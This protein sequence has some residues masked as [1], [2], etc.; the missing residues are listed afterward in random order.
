MR[1]LHV[2]VVLALGLDVRMPRDENGGAWFL[3]FNGPALAVALY[4]TLA[5]ITLIKVLDHLPGVFALRRP[6][7]SVRSGYE[8]LWGAAILAAVAGFRCTGV[9]EGRQDP[10]SR[11][12]SAE[13]GSAI[14]SSLPFA[15]LCVFALLMWALKLRAT[16]VE[17][18]RR[19]EQGTP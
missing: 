1:L 19:L 15:A 17:A 7:G 9:V 8:Y 14:D 2:L 13:Y 5:T 11:Y 18:N 4:G 12:W 16:M 10:G 6:L 3:E